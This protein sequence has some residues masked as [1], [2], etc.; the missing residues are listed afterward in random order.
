M[1]TLLPPN[2]SRLE[3]DLEQSLSRA[4]PVNLLSLWQPEN[5]PLDLLPWLAWAFSV[6]EWDSAWPEETK[7]AVVKESVYI[8]RHKGTKA[9]VNRALKLAHA[10]DVAVLTEWFEQGRSG[11]PRTFWITLPDSHASIANLAGQSLLLK[12]V[13][14]AKPVSAHR[15][16]RLLADDAVVQF[17]QGHFYIPSTARYD[18]HLPIIHKEYATISQVFDTGM[19][20]LLEQLE[21]LAAVIYANESVKTDSLGINYELIIPPDNYVQ[22]IHPKPDGVIVPGALQFTTTLTDDISFSPNLGQ[23]IQLIN[24]EQIIHLNSFYSANNFSLNQNYVV[25]VVPLVNIMRQPLPT[26]GETKLGQL[27]ITDNLVQFY[28]SGM[29]GELRQLQ[30][31]GGLVT[32]DSV[33]YSGIWGVNTRCEIMPLPVLQIFQQLPTKFDGKSGLGYIAVERQII[34]EDWQALTGLMTQ[35][36]AQSSNKIQ[37]NLP[38]AADSVTLNQAPAKNLTNDTPVFSR[39]LPPQGTIHAGELRETIDTPV[40]IQSSHLGRMKRAP[41]GEWMLT[42][43][44]LTADN[45][46][47]NHI[48]EQLPANNTQVFTQYVPKHGSI[49]AGRFTDLI[50]AQAITVSS[51]FAVAGAS[52]NPCETF[53][54]NSEISSGISTIQLQTTTQTGFTAT[55]PLQAAQLITNHAAAEILPQP[56]LHVAARALPYGIRTEQV[57]AGGV[58]ESGEL[59]SQLNTAIGGKSVQTEVTATGFDAVLSLSADS[60]AVLNTTQ[61]P[62][63]KLQADTAMSGY[64]LNWA[65]ENTQQTATFPIVEAVGIEQLTTNHTAPLQKAKSHLKVMHPKPEG[66]ITAGRVS[67]SAEFPIN[68]ETS[69]FVRQRGRA[70]WAFNDMSLPL[71]WDLSSFGCNQSFSAQEKPAMQVVKPKPDGNVSAGKIS[72]DASLESYL[73]NA[74]LVQQQD[75]IFF[76]DVTVR[77]GKAI[78]ALACN[79]HLDKPVE[80]VVKVVHPKPEGIVSV[81]QLI[82]EIPLNMDSN[83]APFTRNTAREDWDFEGITAACTL[84]TY[85]L[86]VGYQHA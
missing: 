41:I 31:G 84:Q 43:I 7:R 74:L 49:S 40:G 2:S 3:R 34:Q 61:S 30:A 36:T 83:L 55:L 6:D 59:V 47:L 13:D 75:G 14:A 39:P 5:C 46:A 10:S 11:I 77:G 54:N 68:Q 60:Q 57:V 73:S 72:V 50:T 19:G 81:G 58:V 44:P 16:M 26:I 21:P 67:T 38:F 37:V 80:K 48:Y 86:T 1:K 63:E 8:H 29:G 12:L 23:V 28:A 70:S 33:H 24:G 56:S 85:C 51:V 71:G 18:S 17:T 22:A 82:T 69:L 42:P 20:G 52:E 15:K 9:A 64:A 62:A 32:T 78:D 45:F 53:L 35:T 27:I 65:A 76:S 4:L 79:H 66:T 25:P